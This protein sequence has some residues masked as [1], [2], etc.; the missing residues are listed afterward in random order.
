LKNALVFTS[1]ATVLRAVPGI[2]LGVG[3]VVTYHN[4]P[5]ALNGTPLI[6]AYFIRRLPFSVRASVSSLRQLS[7]DTEEALV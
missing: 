4:P 2:V 3:L 5:L 1:I 6:L 7:R